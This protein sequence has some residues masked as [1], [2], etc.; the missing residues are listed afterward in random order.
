MGQWK[1]KARG[2][3]AD[4]LDEGSWQKLRQEGCGCHPECG[5]SPPCPSEG[6]KLHLLFEQ[7]KWNRI[8]VSGLENYK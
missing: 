7:K 4:L 1:L 8:H 2:V 3:I 5:L 6:Q